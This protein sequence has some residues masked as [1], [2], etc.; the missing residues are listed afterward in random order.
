MTFWNTNID[1]FFSL[2]LV[3]TRMRDL[4]TPSLTSR[5][6]YDELRTLL[7]LHFKPKPL[8]IME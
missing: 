4:S 5:K 1:Q 7:L 6:T 3:P 8:E 2:L